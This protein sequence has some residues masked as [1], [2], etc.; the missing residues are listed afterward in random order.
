MR[1]SLYLQKVVRLLVEYRFLLSLGLSGTC[2]IMLNSIF[3]MS[4]AHPLM[5]LI[6]LERPTVFH[7][8]VGSYSLFLYSTPF[9]LFS[10]FFSLL[11]VHLYKTEQ[12]LAAG[13]LP[14]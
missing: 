1:Q 7:T 5:R 14:P 6:E 13:T 2:G 3:P 9:L 10:M 11:Y 8:V 4:A 12:E